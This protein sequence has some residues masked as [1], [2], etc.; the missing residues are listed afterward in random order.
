MSKTR[1][2]HK[3]HRPGRSQQQV[4]NLLLGAAHAQAR[5]MG[6]FAGYHPCPCRDCMEIAIGG[7]QL[8][9]GGYDDQQPGLCGDCATALCDADGETEC[10]S[11]AQEEEADQAQ[12]EA[13]RNALRRT[14]WPRF[15]EDWR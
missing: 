6:P 11:T 7:R 4:A 1:E 3:E 2:Q 5:I 12:E 9:G 15:G 10:Q 8:I 13:D 14:R